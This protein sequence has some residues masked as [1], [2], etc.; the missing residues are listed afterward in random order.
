MLT[1]FVEIWVS[2]IF[3]LHIQSLHM[4]LCKRSWRSSGWMW[5]FMWRQVSA[6]F[7]NHPT[8]CDFCPAFCPTHALNTLQQDSLEDKHS[9]CTE[10][11]SWSGASGRCPLA[12][13]CAHLGAC[14]GGLVMSQ[15]G[16]MASALLAVF[17]AEPEEI[18]STHLDVVTVIKIYEC[19]WQQISIM[20][21]MTA[22]E[23]SK[24]CTHVI[25]SRPGIACGQN[26]LIW[27]P[28]LENSKP[29]MLQ[30]KPSS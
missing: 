4:S 1:Q 23:V 5:L 18:A 25:V 8:P 21:I 7:N 20:F 11:E 6:Y 14:L 16:A 19:S 22:L 15:F 24:L 17:K 30:V 12:A 29:C 10:Q 3:P 13:L 26:T 2:I 9:R 28:R 27:T